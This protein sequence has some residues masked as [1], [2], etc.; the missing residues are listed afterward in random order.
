MQKLKKMALEAF[1]NG[2]VGQVGLSAFQIRES[3]VNLQHTALTTVGRIF[4]R[5]PAAIKNSAH[6]Q[7]HHKL[8]TAFLL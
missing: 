8:L 1:S 7:H 4:A 5:N 6:Q 2:Q 3:K